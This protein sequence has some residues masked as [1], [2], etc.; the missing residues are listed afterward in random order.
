MKLELK[1]IAPYLPYGL[2]FCPKSEPETRLAIGNI[3]LKK[4]GRLTVVNVLDIGTYDHV[5]SEWKTDQI[6]LLL[7]PLS[8]LTKPIEHKGERFVPIIELAKLFHI[9][10]KY[11]VTHYI[12]ARV[13]SGWVSVKCCV[14]NDDKRYMDYDLKPDMLSNDFREIQKLFEWHFDVFGLLDHG[15]AIDINTLTEKV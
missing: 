4:I 5:R 2:T 8:D 1:H 10:P 12:D 7:R 6:Q 9:N 15:L 13:D 14:E 11:T 3:Y